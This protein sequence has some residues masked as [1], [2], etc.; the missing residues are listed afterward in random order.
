MCARARCS[1]CKEEA[2]K[3]ADVPE[4]KWKDIDKFEPKYNIQPGSNALVVV[5]DGEARTSLTV[6]VYRDS[7][8][9]ARKGSNTVMTRLTYHMYPWRFGMQGTKSIQAMQWG[10][11]PSWTK[12]GE[13]KPD[14]FR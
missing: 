5:K 13:A 11:V 4:E 2:A 10:L 1:L 3:K 9:C 14:F 7:V 8:A 6:R 12:D